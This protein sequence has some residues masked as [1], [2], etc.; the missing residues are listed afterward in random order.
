MGTALVGKV[1]L[2]VNNSFCRLASQEGGSL[3]LEE[4]VLPHG[5]AADRSWRGLM[6]TSTYVLTRSSAWPWSWLL[7][8]GAGLKGAKR[9]LGLLLVLVS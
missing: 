5:R 1:P 9:L 8:Y 3:W 7:L 6:I 4:M 2:P